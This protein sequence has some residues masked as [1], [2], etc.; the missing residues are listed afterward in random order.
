MATTAPGSPYVESSDLVANYPAVSEALAERV[1]TVGVLPFADST[2]RGTAIPSPTEGQYT[3]LQDTNATEYWDGS[4]WV[5]AGAA[6]GLVLVTP[7]SIANSGGS[8]SLS[9]GAVT[10]TGVTSVSLNGVFTSAYQ[11]YRIVLNYYASDYDDFFRIRM[12]AAGTD[13]AGS[14]TY[15]SQYVYWRAGSMFPDGL[16]ADYARFAKIGNGQQDSAT[17]DV[18]NPQLAVSTRLH[19]HATYGGSSNGVVDNYLATMLHTAATAY[20][21]ITLWPSTPDTMTGTARIYGYQN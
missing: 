13:A 2:A 5:A 11:N 4:A 17:I 8:A 12:R 9:G 19:S 7:T 3:Y 14:N 1:D 10:F 16:L 15:R 21:G 18:F 6:P 20:D